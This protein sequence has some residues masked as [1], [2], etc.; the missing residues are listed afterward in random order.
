MILKWSQ[1]VLFTPVYHSREAER[2]PGK[3]PRPK[4]RFNCQPCVPMCGIL[5]NLSMTQRGKGDGPFP[6]VQ[7]CAGGKGNPVLLLSPVYVWGLSRLFWAPVL[8]SVLSQTFCS[9]KYCDAVIFAR[10]VL[11][12]LALE[13]LEK[14]PPPPSRTP[15]PGPTTSTR[16]ASNPSGSLKE[17]AIAPSKLLYPQGMFIPLAAIAEKKA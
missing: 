9:P 17:D 13:R 6:P 1:L 10:I 15:A 5:E 2:D 3:Q 7:H 12:T 16:R 8:G 4:W 14:Q 11:K